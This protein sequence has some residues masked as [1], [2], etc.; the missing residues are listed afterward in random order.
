MILLKQSNMPLYASA[1][2]AVAVCSCLYCLNG[3]SYWEV[4]RSLH[5][6]LDNVERVPEDVSIFGIGAIGRYLLHDQ[7]LDRH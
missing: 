3:R 1:P 5:A 6:S 7:D 2:V 4:L